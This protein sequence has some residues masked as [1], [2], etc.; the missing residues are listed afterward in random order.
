MNCK[1]F[2]IF[3]ISY[4]DTVRD[5]NFVRGLPLI[6]EAIAEAVVCGVDSPTTDNFSRVN[7][8][9]TFESKMLLFSKKTIVLNLNFHNTTIFGILA[10]QM[11]Y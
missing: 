4:V 5:Y 11:Y 3:V 6:F 7:Y 10:T 1:R 8:F 2:I 9:D